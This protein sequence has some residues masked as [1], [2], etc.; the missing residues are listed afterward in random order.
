MIKVEVVDTT[1]EISSP[2]CGMMNHI[3]PWL[4]QGWRAGILEVL[5]QQIK[6]LTRHLYSV[7][8]EGEPAVGV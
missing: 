4:L 3:S 7:D 6:S 8:T 1:N 5:G 2:G